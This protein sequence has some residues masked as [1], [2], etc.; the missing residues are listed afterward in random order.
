MAIETDET[1]F[2]I[3]VCKS[4][5]NT[6]MTANG[7]LAVVEAYARVL[8]QLL[9]AKHREVSIEGT[10]RMTEKQYPNMPLNK[11]SIGVNPSNQ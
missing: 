8:N 6:N 3:V 2:L 7:K 5:L 9:E 11:T 10:R 1:D 4:M